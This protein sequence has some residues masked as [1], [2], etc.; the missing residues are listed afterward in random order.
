[1]DEETKARFLELVEKRFVDL[2]VRELGFL[3]GALDR[4]EEEILELLPEL[5][6]LL[7]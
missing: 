7:S 3:L 2:T 4:F 5:R 6:P 1:M